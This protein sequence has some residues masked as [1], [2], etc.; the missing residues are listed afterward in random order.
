MLGT[1]SISDEMAHMH[2]ILGYRAWRFW[3]KLLWMGSL[4]ATGLFL[5]FAFPKRLVGIGTAITDRPG[6]ALLW[7]VGGIILIPVACCILFVTI[8]GVPLGLIL[9]SIFLWLAYL[10]QLSLG[11]VAG[12]RLFGT[13][14]KKGW[15]LV[16]G[17]AVGLVIVQAL[18]FVPYLRFLVVAAGFVLGMGAILLA[19]KSEIQV[20]R[21][22]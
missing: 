11:V 6:E 21:A 16:W 9:L 3:F 19:M 8:I 2:N 10:S 1:V 14:R 18:T 13:E 12:H 20:H 7:G 17:F 5:I 15:G 22:K 4:L